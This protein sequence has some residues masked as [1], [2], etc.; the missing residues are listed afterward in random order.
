[1]PLAAADRSE[2]L[3]GRVESM[4]RAWSLQSYARIVLFRS[5]AV[6]TSRNQWAM[7]RKPLS[8]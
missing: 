7:H 1:M 3:C 6:A 2:S 8:P 4:L 5:M